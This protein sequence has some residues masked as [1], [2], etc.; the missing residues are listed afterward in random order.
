MKINN[1][2]YAIQNKTTRFY[3]SP[4]LIRDV[5]NYK[6]KVLKPSTNKKLGKIVHKGHLRDARMYTLTLIERETCT[7]ECEH[8][9]DCYG[10][11][12]M[13]AHRFEVNAKFMKRLEQDIKELNNKQKKF[14]VRLHVLGDFNSKEYVEF[15]DRML[16][17]N[18]YLY[19]YGYTRNHVNSKYKNIRS[20]GKAIIKTRAKYDERFAIRFSNAINE[21][22]SANSEELT[23]K[24]I[25]CLAQ[26]KEEVTCADCTLC[27]A[28]K[29]SVRFL[30]H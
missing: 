23:D 19:I 15:W 17:E 2:H 8:W 21:E 10:N 1:E 25:T 30:T 26:V 9:H 14:L 5:S 20:I 29:K 4:N 12:M 16:S 6:F 7:N 22:F 3:K 18:D 24:G 28:S 27:W 11:G 13:Y